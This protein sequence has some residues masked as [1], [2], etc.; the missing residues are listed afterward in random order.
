MKGR[1]VGEDKGNRLA[2]LDGEV[3]EGLQVFAVK[4]GRRS[5]D[6]TLRS[7]DGVDRVVLETVYPWHGSP[8]VETHHELSLE[9]HFARATG[10]DPH[11][12]GAVCRR[13]KVDDHRTAGISLEF[14]FED[15]GAGAITP[16]YAD[17][18]MFVAMSHRPF[19]LV[20]R[21]AAKHAGESKRGQ[22]SQSIEPSRPTKAAALQSPISA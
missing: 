4:C 11:K 8:I 20:P 1:A 18:R 17:R 13:H 19:S 5:Q 12:V 3:A 16:I 2:G 10:D 14:G 15:E 22:H 7:S 6:K 9:N 21:S